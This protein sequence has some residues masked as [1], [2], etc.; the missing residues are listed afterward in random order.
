MKTV[1]SIGKERPTKRVC[2]IVLSA[3]IV[4]DDGFIRPLNLVTLVREHRIRLCAIGDDNTLKGVDLV[5]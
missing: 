2:L 3:C 5:K 4:A 1:H